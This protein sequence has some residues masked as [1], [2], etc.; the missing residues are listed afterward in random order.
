MLYLNETF[1]AFN[2]IGYLTVGDNWKPEAAYK[3]LL[4]R[5]NFSG[6]GV[7]IGLNEDDAI[8]AAE[9]QYVLLDAGG[10]HFFKLVVGHYDGEALTTAVTGLRRRPS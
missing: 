7:I 3:L 9:H 2:G 10:D 1:G 4:H 8:K 6:G 5:G